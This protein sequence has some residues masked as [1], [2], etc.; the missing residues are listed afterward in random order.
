MGYSDRDI[1]KQ[2]AKET[3]E[4][5]ILKTVEELNELSTALTQLLT[6]PKNPNY[7]AVNDEMGDVMIRISILVEKKVFDNK[8][9]DERIEEKLNHLLNKK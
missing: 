2:A 5:S 7:K 3:R 9:V 4:Y 6:K 8:A 1:Q